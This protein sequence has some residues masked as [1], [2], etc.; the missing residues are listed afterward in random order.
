MVV[1]TATAFDAPG[2]K[3]E[4][5]KGNLVPFSATT[6]PPQCGQV[7]DPIVEW[8]T[9]FGDATPQSQQT[10]VDQNVQVFS[11]WILGP[12]EGGLGRNIEIIIER[13][14]TFVAVAALVIAQVFRDVFETRE[15]S[16][17][18]KKYVGIDEPRAMLFRGS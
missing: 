3:Q 16:I 12:E 6:I 10:T 5:P 2:R 4:Q 17:T 15:E 7:E 11:R 9:I 8:V 18:V 14:D 13:H 1:A